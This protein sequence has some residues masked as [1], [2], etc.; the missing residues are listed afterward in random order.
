MENDRA[1][2]RRQA[3]IH[4]LVVS[5]R[6]VDGVKGDV[7]AG[8]KRLILRLTCGH[9]VVKVDRRRFLVGEKIRCLHCMKAAPRQQSLLSLWEHS[10]L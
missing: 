7:W 6:R 2:Y 1:K 3:P 4:A 5:C 8:R 10:D 9:D